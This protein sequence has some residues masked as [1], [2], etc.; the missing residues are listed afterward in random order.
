[1]IYIYTTGSNKNY[2]IEMEYKKIDSADI[3]Y[4]Y[5]TYVSIFLDGNACSWFAVCNR[6]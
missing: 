3:V 2:P 4:D 6:L 1:M 5:E